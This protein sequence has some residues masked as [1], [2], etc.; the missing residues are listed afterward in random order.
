MSNRLHCLS[1]KI[2]REASMLNGSL[3]VHMDFV[4][5]GIPDAVRISFK[6][7]DGSALDRICTGLGDVITDLL[8]RAEPATGRLEEPVPCEG[9]TLSGAFFVRMDLADVGTPDAVQVRFEG[10]D[11]TARHICAAISAAITGI[12]R[13]TRP[14]ARK[15][16]SA[17]RG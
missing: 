13:E 5:I 6:G 10:T 15:T 9:L 2:P 17:G 8:H 3:F 16:G 12:L 1:E 4:E 11:P 14:A 7:K